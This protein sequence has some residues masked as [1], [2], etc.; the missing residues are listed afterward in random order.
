MLT[1]LLEGET[2]FEIIDTMTMSLDFTAMKKRM[3]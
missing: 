2:D 1:S 3:C